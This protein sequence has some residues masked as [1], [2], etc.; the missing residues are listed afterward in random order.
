MKQSIDRFIK[1][2]GPGMLYAGAAIGVSHL[3][4]STRA[5][6]SFG[7]WPI[8][9][10]VFIHIAKYP[11][12]KAGPKF[13][14]LSGM[15][16]I[17][18][19]AN[20]GK[21]LVWLFFLITIGTMFT[22]IAAIVAVTSG[23]CAYLFRL[24]LEPNLVS[25]GVMSIAT[26]L[27]ILGGYSW[28][29]RMMKIIILL[30]G[31]CTMIAFTSAFL[32]PNLN[33]LVHLLPVMDGVLLMMLI[34]L[35]GWMPAPLDLSVWHSL[36]VLKNKEVTGNINM[37]DTMR[38]FNFGYWGTMVMGVLFLGMGAMILHGSDQ[39]I[40]ASGVAFS[41]MLIGMYTS[42]LGQWAFYIVG[43]AALA[44]MLSTTLTCLDAIP[45]SLVECKK[46]IMKRVGR[47]DYLV[48]LLILSLGSIILLTILSASMTTMVD[49]ATIISF[50]S[51]PIIAWM[52]FK[53][54]RSPDIPAQF[55]PSSLSTN[56]EIISI[57]SLAILSLLYFFV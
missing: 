3:V 9:A 4:Q 44:T 54:M 28:L 24:E 32:E 37:E 23:I 17:E 56:W 47:Y 1:T 48:L 26:T 2:L 43:T 27:L 39:E 12:F 20:R 31:I 22:I 52:N 46:V 42:Q 6:A 41:N 7:W 5:G 40:P 36:W 55:R 16:L 8:I 11:F 45:R 21:S 51:A 19:Y 18:G 30:L 25:I 35:M 33:D 49:I 14:L 10:I 13:A 53:V 15:S 57:L 50:C 29:N 34:K 38:D